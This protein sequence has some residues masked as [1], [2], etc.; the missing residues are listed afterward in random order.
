[1]NWLFIHVTHVFRAEQVSQLAISELQ[2]THWFEEIV[3]SGL[4]HEVHSE[5]DAHVTQLGMSEAQLKHEDEE[6]TY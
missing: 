2:S 1:V 4:E 5:A 3:Y 6:I